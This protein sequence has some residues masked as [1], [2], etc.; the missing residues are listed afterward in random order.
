MYILKTKRL[1]GQKVNKTLSPEQ[2]G[3]S[4]RLY[5]KDDKSIDEYPKILL[6]K[7]KEKVYI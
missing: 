4:L 7:L 2:I 5:Y 3:S 1:Q 6:Q